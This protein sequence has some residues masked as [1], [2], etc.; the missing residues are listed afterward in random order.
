MGQ[1][2]CIRIYA[3]F[4]YVDVGACERASIRLFLVGMRLMCVRVCARA[5]Q[6]V[7]ACVG[8]FLIVPTI[9]TASLGTFW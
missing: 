9:F 2:E 8:A 7:R 5:R 4:A 1:C 3:R 6:C